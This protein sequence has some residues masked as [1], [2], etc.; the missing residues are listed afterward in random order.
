[1]RPVKVGSMRIDLVSEI[2]ALAFDKAWLFANI[3]DEVIAA[4][5]SWLDH[6][7]IEPET[8]RFILSHH[9]Y[10]VRT[11]RWTAVVDTCCGNHKHRPRVPAWNNLDRPYLENMQALGVAPEQVDFV[12]CTHLHVDH[13]GW[14]TR[15]LNGRWVPTFPNA[16]YLFARREW[17]HWREAELRAAYTT[18]PYY[19]DSLLPVMDSGQAELVAMDYAFDDSV[20]IEPW[21]GHTPGHVCVIARSPQASVILSGDIMHTALQCAEP[22]LNSCFCVDAETAR[23]TRRRFLETFTDS[24][25]MVIP[26]HLPTPSAGW[27]RSH[28]GAF[29]FHFDR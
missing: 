27:I 11:P 20:W 13:V 15:L 25:V 28:D 8:G 1:M 7:Y 18:D 29:R 24:P 17:E 14:N 23:A 3:T 5:R 4:N 6:R 2:A 10:L 12:M 9:S 22:Q 26:A 21:P 19:E 16:R